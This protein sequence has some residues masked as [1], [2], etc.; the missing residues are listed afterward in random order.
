MNKAIQIIAPAE[1]SYEQFCGQWIADVK[2]IFAPNEA[3]TGRELRRENIAQL[4][5]D[6]LNNDFGDEELVW[7]EDKSAGINAYFWD[8]DED[9]APLMRVVRFLLSADLPADGRAVTREVGALCKT[10]N[11]APASGDLEPLLDFWR[12]PEANARLVMTFVSPNQL[13]ARER[14]ALPYAA[15][16]LASNANLET[17]VKRFRCTRFTRAIMWI[18]AS[19]CRYACAVIWTP[20]LSIAARLISISPQLNGHGQRGRNCCPL[21]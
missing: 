19:R 11:E 20:V 7:I 4:L 17:S 3:P 8:N 21:S 2:A 16:I 15:A 18:L 12:R 1:I 13:P 6:G 9:D 14:D 10:L 5:R